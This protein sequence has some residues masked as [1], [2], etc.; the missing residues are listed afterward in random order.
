VAG[1]LR[2]QPGE[3]VVE[4]R[5]RLGE[6]DGVHRVAEADPQDPAGGDDL[7][8][9]VGLV[10]ERREAKCGAQRGQPR[11]DPKGARAD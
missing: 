3:R 2:P 7:V 4:R 10:A 11:D 9:V 6:A 1:H 8:V 5:R